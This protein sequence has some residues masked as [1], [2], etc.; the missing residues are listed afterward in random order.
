[1]FG[2]RIIE[3]INDSICVPVKRFCVNLT[4]SRTKIIFSLHYNDDESYW[5]VNKAQICN[6]KGLD[7]MNAYYFHLGSVSKDFTND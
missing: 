4:K 2:E 7:S 5:P 6:Y 3:E 1:M